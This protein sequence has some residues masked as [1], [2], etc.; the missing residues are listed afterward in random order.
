MSELAR[1][2]GII[3]G[4]FI[5]EDPTTLTVGALIANKEVSFA[6]GF[7]A[8]TLGIF[9]GDLGLY[10]LG[11]LFQKKLLKTSKVFFLP[12]AGHIFLARFIPGTRTVTYIA[13]GHGK[14]PFKKFFYL[15]LPS[16]FIWTLL[17]IGFTQEI[18]SISQILP[19]WGNWLA[20]VFLLVCFIY[21]RL[22]VK[23][24]GMMALIATLI[25]HHLFLRN[26]D[27]RK[28]ALS[29][30]AYSRVA[31]RLLGI[32]IQTNVNIEDFSGKLIVSNHMSYLDVICLSSI[33]PGLYVTSTDIQRTPVL[34]LICELCGCVFT[35][36]RLS[37]RT[38]IVAECELKE[39][40]SVLSEGVSLT[41]FPEGTSTDGLRLLP[42]KSPLFEG[43]L[44]A[45]VKL[46]PILLRYI[47]IDG[48]GFSKNN[49]DMVAW[50][51][52]MTFLPHF[53]RLCSLKTLKVQIAALDELD[54]NEFADRK[55]LAREA[56]RLIHEA[57]LKEL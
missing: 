21:W 28:M 37:K 41:L 13:A 55:V 11:I 16:S 23:L 44:R 1:F 20:G 47:E 8:L 54:A 42:F 49:S 48:I 29:L 26:H 46:R 33:Y 57:F 10:A 15:S 2:F 50:H 7:S 24:T 35:E 34:G 17:L 14:V 40:H 52:K 39:I 51:G 3:G 56:Q 43:A 25:V 19:V 32:E 53:I 18:F 5:L 38:P 6:F 12:T 45:K 30:S 36:R 27:R 9:L 4:T 22:I 31:L